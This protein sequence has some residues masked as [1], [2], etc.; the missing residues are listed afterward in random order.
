VTDFDIFARPAPNEG[1]LVE[2]VCQ[3]YAASL[4]E[5]FLDRYRPALKEDAPGLVE[6]LQALARGDQSFAVNWNPVLGRCMST[7]GE[8]NPQKAKRVSIELVLHAMAQGLAGGWETSLNP[9]TVLWQSYCWERVSSLAVQ[10]TGQRAQLRLVNSGEPHLTELVRTDGVWRGTA[11]N[12]M[13][14]LLTDGGAITLLSDLALR[15]DPSDHFGFPVHRNLTDDQVLRFSA[16]LDI[17][18]HFAPDYY[19]WVCCVLRYIIVIYDHDG[20]MRSGSL[21]GRC[22]QVHISD[23]PDPLSIAEMLVHESAHQYFFLL[24]RIDQVVEDQSKLY[25]SPFVQTMRPLDRILMGYHAFA[26][27]VLCYEQ[28]AQTLPDRGADCRARITRVTKDL[29]QICELI[30]DD[31]KFTPLGNALIASISFDLPRSA[32][33]AG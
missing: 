26:N 3:Q 23:N 8:E 22:G 19:R 2:S 30:K 5:L 1:S 11:P 9:A 25:Y 7:L 27:V 17:L 6:M 14:Q 24:T 29:S 4:L 21:Q 31:S 18:K 33:S 32:A 15:D 12:V 20:I 28:F 10:S 13:P 16:A